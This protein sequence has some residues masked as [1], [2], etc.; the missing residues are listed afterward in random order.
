[1]GHFI[2]ILL[3]TFF[4]ITKKTGYYAWRLKAQSETSDFFFNLMSYVPAFACE[5]SS[6]FSVQKYLIYD[7][8]HTF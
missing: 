8:P 6:T 4:R 5:T 2:W 7:V 3:V 1:M